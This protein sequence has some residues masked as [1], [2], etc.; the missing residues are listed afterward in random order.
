MAEVGLAECPGRTNGPDGGLLQSL[1]RRS[2]RG[3]VESPEG[4]SPQG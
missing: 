3:A 2:R 4:L 1:T